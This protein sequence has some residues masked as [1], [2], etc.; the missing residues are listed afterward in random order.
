MRPASTPRKSMGYRLNKG[1]NQ[2]VD[3]ELDYLIL[4]M[5]PGNSG[6]EKELR[7]SQFY[8]GYIIYT[9]DRKI[10]GIR[11]AGKAQMSKE[12]PKLVFSPFYHML[13]K[14]LLMK[15]HEE[16]ETDKAVGIDNIRERGKKIIIKIC[17]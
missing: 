15:C 1:E 12:Q 4:L 8:K 11:L 2:K 9:Q 3:R 14:A 13:N 5:K 6:G 10:M 16:L 17:L 7:Y